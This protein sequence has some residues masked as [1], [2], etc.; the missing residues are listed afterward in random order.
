MFEPIYGS[1]PDIAGKAIANPL[2]SIWSVS[3]M[4]DFFGL[5]AWGKT[6]LKAIE[7]VM[8]HGKCLTSDIGGTART[9]EVGDAV[10]SVISAMKK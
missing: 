8:V 6:I 9:E 7:Q 5:E 10:I 4:F 3:Q 2:A 1:A